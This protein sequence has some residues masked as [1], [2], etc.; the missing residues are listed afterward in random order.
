MLERVNEQLERT[1]TSNLEVVST[2]RDTASSIMTLKQL[3]IGVS[4]TAAKLQVMAADLMFTQHLSP[5]KG[6][7]V[8][9]EDALGRQFSIPAEWLDTIRWEVR[10]T[11]EYP[12]PEKLAD[13]ITE[14][15][16][17]QTLYCLISDWFLNHKGYE[18]VKKR[19]YAIQDS[20]TGNDLTNDRPLRFCLR[21]GMK[22]EMSMLFE[23][24]GRT[25]YGACPR[26]FTR[27]DIRF[28]VSVVW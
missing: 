11:P 1:E 3:V 5:T 19:Q 10:D 27:I 15:H 24:P 9:C 8:V 23:S 2:A 26:C 22:I 20:A 6:L 18:M 16:M 25:I 14:L 4:Q 17:S 13:L 12:P 7:P 21:R 28:G